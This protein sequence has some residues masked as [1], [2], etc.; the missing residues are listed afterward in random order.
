MSKA[1]LRGQR[2]GGGPEPQSPTGAQRA[3]RDYGTAPRENKE[4][5]DLGIRNLGRRGWGP[6][7][8]ASHVWTAFIVFIIPSFSLNNLNIVN[9]PDLRA[10][11]HGCMVSRFLVDLLDEMN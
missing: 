4:G 11:M 5:L 1:W 6:G 10:A 3:L 2:A 9:L 8:P 7:N